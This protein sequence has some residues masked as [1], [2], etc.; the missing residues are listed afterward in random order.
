M[1]LVTSRGEKIEKS[2]IMMYNETDI[3]VNA[4]TA[5]AQYKVPFNSIKSI[6]GDKFTLN[7]DGD[8]IYT[9]DKAVKVTIRIA[10]K[11]TIS[12]ILYVHS[13]FGSSSYDSA[14][15]NKPSALAMDIFKDK[16]TF[17]VWVS[18]SVAENITFSQGVGTY[19]ILEEI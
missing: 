17:N 11:D 2:S 15:S 9:G 8:V 1:A 19:M 14:T 18:D 10:R 12:G 7:D 4:T 6:V 5:W 13:Y 3:T 16:K